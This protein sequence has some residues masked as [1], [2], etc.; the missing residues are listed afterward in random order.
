MDCQLNNPGVR[1]QLKKGNQNVDPQKDNSVTQIG[2][3]FWVD[4]SSLSIGNDMK[5]KCQALSGGLVVLEKTVTLVKA[6][7]LNLM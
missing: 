5:L 4:V 2:Q 3:K 1:V 6:K 7:G